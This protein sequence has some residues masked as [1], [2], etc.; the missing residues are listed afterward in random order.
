MRS[1]SDSTETW[2]QVIVFLILNH[3]NTENCWQNMFFFSEMTSISR[4]PIFSEKPAPPTS[5]RDTSASGGSSHYSLHIPHFFRRLNASA[6]VGFPWKAGGYSHGK[7][8]VL[9]TG[10]YSSGP[11]GAVVLDSHSWFIWLPALLL[12]GLCQTS[13]RTRSHSHHPQSGGTSSELC[14]FWWNWSPIITRPPLQKL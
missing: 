14:S 8:C 6:V 3:K 7:S 10:V 11:V 13:V 1:R 5:T 9:E 4:N 2:N 12:S